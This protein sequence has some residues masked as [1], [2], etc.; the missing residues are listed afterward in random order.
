MGKV[1]AWLMEM[2]DYAIGRSRE[3]FLKKYP[4]EGDVWE[5]ANDPRQEYDE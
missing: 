1:K 2:E 3:E 5:H 4:G